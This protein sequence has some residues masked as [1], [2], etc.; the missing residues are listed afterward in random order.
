MDLKVD[1]LH[2]LNFLGK[3]HEGG[4]SNQIIT[5]GEKTKKNNVRKDFVLFDMNLEINP[6]SGPREGND[7]QQP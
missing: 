6:L 4:K 1:Y 7:K 2:P 5:L 3:N